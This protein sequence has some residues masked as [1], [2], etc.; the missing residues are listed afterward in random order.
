M[1]QN[2]AAI[3]L[4]VSPPDTATGVEVFVPEP[5]PS[6]PASLRPQQY[7]A[8]PVVSAQVCSKPAASGRAR[9]GS[10]YLKQPLQVPLPLLEELT[11]TSL[12]PSS[13][14]ASVVPV[15][16]VAVTTVRLPS[17]LPPMV[18]LVTLAKLLP[19][20]VTLVPPASGPLAGL[21]A[22]TVTGAGGATE[23]LQPGVTRA[24][25]RL[26]RTALALVQV[27]SVPTLNE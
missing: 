21:T 25:T 13:L 19:V 22:V 4:N 9:T 2:P 16:W 10:R 7:A 6:W 17:S 12:A 8:P 11:T 18:T 24:A 26:P 23:S 3:A 5:S 27:M 1:C 14:A 15:I 20:I